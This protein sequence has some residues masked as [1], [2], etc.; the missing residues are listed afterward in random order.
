M[1]GKKQE[2]IVTAPTPLPADVAFHVMPGKYQ[3]VVGAFAPPQKPPTT[4][5][6]VSEVPG[7]QKAKSPGGKKMLFIWGSIALVVFLAGGLAL[8]FLQPKKP[9]EQPQPEVPP[10]AE[11]PEPLPA[12][13]PSPAPEAPPSVV[14]EAP[15]VTPTPEVLEPPKEVVASLDTDQDGLTDAEEA[16][17]TTDPLK[18]DMDSDGYLDGQ[19]VVNL[20]NPTGT[21][22]IRIADSALVK[23]YTNTA[24]GYTILYPASWTF[25]A[26]DEQNP[27]EVLFTAATGEFVQV[28]VDDN[29]ENLSALQWYG[30]QSPD[31]RPESLERVFVENLDGVWTKD[32]TTVYVTKTVHGSGKRFLFGIT[33]NYGERTE[34]NFKTT[35][36][37]MVESFR[38]Q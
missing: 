31:V 14:V 32:K 17:Y 4:P 24:F 38:V 21:A 12:E 26:L 15:P 9:P 33:Y 27:R 35:L 18:P 6:P 13:E 34:V 20:Y 5:P 11:T 30:K 25:R 3:G 1:F 8:V 28:I 37:M 16:L 36:M 10:V 2:K 22:P 19:E 7:S 23:T 29:A